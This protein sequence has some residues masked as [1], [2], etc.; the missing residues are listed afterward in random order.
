MDDRSPEPRKTEKTGLNTLLAKVYRP[1]P[2]IA[3]FILAFVALASLGV[4][5]LTGETPPPEVIQ[6]GPA[7]MP[8]PATPKEYEEATSD[9]EDFVKQADLAIIETL[10][11]LD[12]PMA[13][14]DLVDVELRRFE[15][16][17]YHYQ[18][19]Q[20]PKVDDRK[21]FSRHP[22]ASACSSACPT[23]PCWITATTRPWSRSTA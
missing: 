13:D 5:L 19:L 21:P 16:R 1:G 10:R 22:C 18:V 8:E 7:Q 3:I 9:M 17:D 12:L 14:L 15:D 6:A 4:S 20:F 2:L 23:P 11:E